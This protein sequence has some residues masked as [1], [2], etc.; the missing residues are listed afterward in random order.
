[1]LGGDLNVMTVPNLTSPVVEGGPGDIRIE[2]VEDGFRVRFEPER[3]NILGGLLA[4]L[5]S[6]DIL[7]RLP[8]DYGLV[9]EATAGD[10][11]LQ[12]VKYLC[13]RMRAGD[14]TADRL[15]GVDFSMTAGEFDATLDLRPGRHLVT[16]GAGNLDVDIVEGSD[17]AVTG[18]VSIGDVESKVPGLQRRSS[19]LGGSLSGVLGAGAARLDLRVTT[20]DLDIG[21]ARR[22]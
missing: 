1:M 6:G 5:R 21:L 17:V 15:E 19:G 12:G 18:R 8:P 22:V 3:G 11:D 9:V 13:G 7:L 4:S 2:D 16:V 14:I 10:V 20:G